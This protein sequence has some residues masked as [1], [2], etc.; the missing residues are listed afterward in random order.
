[1]NLKHGR[2]TQNGSWISYKTYN[3][4]TGIGNIQKSAKKL[5]AFLISKGVSS[6]VEDYEVHIAVNSSYRRGCVSICAFFQKGEIPEE[7][8]NSIPFENHFAD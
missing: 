4:H 3:Y 6:K 7:V 5:H 8:M 1:M 2:V